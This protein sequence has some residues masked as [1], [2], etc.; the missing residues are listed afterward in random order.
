MAVLCFTIYKYEFTR[1]RTHTNIETNWTTYALPIFSI[2]SSSETKQ[3][4]SILYL[5]S[6]DGAVSKD[7]VAQLVRHSGE[8]TSKDEQHGHC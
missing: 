1:A 4:F 2:H 7:S 8:N 5:Y 3:F 6:E